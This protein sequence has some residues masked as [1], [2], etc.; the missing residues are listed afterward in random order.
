MFRTVST[1]PVKLVRGASTAPRSRARGPEALSARP[2]RVADLPWVERWLARFG[3]PP[4]PPQGT[5]FVLLAGESRVGFVA[6]ERPRRPDLDLWISVAFLIPSAQGR[7]WMPRF[8]EL[9]S[10]AGFSEGKVGARVAASN[11]PAQRVLRAAGFVPASAGG[12]YLDF[13]L[14][15]ERPFVV[16]G[17]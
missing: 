10:R 7:G 3:L 12:R 16:G 17:G 5:Q 11:A 9:L 15:L 14:S 4:P 13:E 6:L 1:S 2:R 8:G